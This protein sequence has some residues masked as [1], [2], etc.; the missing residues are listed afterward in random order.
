M[1]D[2]DASVTPFPLF[3]TNVRSLPTMS[4]AV[5]QINTELIGTHF[6]GFRVSSITIS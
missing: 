2:E 5:M 3:A 6:L 4:Y 1:S